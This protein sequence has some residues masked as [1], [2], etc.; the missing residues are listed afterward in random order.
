M[1]ATC[2]G[3]RQRRPKAVA[4]AG[5]IGSSFP[6]CLFPEERP[7]SYPLLTFHSAST[8]ASCLNQVAGWFSILLGRGAS[9]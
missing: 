8:R 6:C 2:S 5:E 4:V 7:G 1:L 9:R 3:R